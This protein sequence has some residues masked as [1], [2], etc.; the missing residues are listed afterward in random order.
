MSK[1]NIFEHA[2]L[3]YKQTQVGN[4]FGDNWFC[5]MAFTDSNLTCKDF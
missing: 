3:K 4:G 2:D 1:L 5:L